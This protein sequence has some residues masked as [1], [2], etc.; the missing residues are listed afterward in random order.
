MNIVIEEIGTTNNST[1]SQMFVDNRALCFVIEDGY[2]PVK[3]SDETRIPP[4][5]YQI[6]K[7]M[8]GKFYEKYKKD[9]G[10]KWVPHLQKVPGFEFI[11]I[12]IGNTPKDTSGCLLVAR[13]ISMNLTTGDYNGIDSGSIYK[14]LYSLMNAAFERGEEIWIEIQRREI[15]DL[16]QEFG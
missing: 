1:A 9:F 4:G 12:H 3:I 5:R 11:L 8:A 6:K 2:R 14:L 16:T 7:R 15:L 13:G 10:H